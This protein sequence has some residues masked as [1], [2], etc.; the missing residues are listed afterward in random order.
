MAEVMQFTDGSTTIQLSPL[1]DPNYERPDSR[2]RG[3]FQPDAG[4]RQYWDTGGGQKHSI[5]LNNVS[6]TNAD[7]LNTWWQ[8][9]TILTFTPDLTG[10]P[11]TT[12]HVRVINEQKPI[13][14]WF[15]TGWQTKYQ[16]T[17]V[18]QEV[19]SSSSSS[20]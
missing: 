19:S 5:G 4:Y 18:V 20:G 13:Q 16:G 1:V 15:P 17:L 3:Y 6:K 9:L 10:A 12:I 2:D 7:Q 8:S 14:M 11:G